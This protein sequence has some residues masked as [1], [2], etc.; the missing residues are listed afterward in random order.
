[1]SLLGPGGSRSGL[2]GAPI[3]AIG[4]QS[5]SAVSK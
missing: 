4:R 5:A 2:G 1:M 3:G